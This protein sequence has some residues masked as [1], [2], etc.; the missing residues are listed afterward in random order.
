MKKKTWIIICVI[1]SIE[2]MVF[3]GM[4]G[5]THSFLGWSGLSFLLVLFLIDCET[6]ENQRGAK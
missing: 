4:Q 2:N 3:A 1:T 5:N 6:S